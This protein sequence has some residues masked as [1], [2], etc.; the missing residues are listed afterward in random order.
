[1]NSKKRVFM[2]I[3]VFCSMAAGAFGGAPDVISNGLVEIRI[4]TGRGR[5]DI[6]DLKRNQ[7]IIS[8]SQ[9][10]FS[11]APYVELSN[12]AQD[13]FETE[14]KLTGIKSANCVN[15]ANSQGALKS[16]SSKGKS[17]SMISR[18]AGQGQL[19]V[20]FTLYPKETF[21][22]ISFAFKNLNTR[23][24][25][26]RKVNVIDCDRFMPG[27]DRAALKLHNGVCGARKT[28]VSKVR[29]WSRKTIFSVSLP[30]K[31]SHVHSLQG[32]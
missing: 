1:M 28:I 13:A 15:T 21:V 19:Q 6:I 27:C 7:S 31:N 9:I 17:I 3:T 29:I 30:T 26:L 10:G 24:I 8:D 12:V 25:R 11:I 5:F 23:P 22:E 16:A 4:D 14:Q 20:Q 2:I 32:G 18:K